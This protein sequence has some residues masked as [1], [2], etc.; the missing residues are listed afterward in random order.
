MFGGEIAIAT[1]VAEC[2]RTPYILGPTAAYTLPQD[3]A[4]FTADLLLGP[5]PG[6]EDNLLLPFA[7]GGCVEAEWMVF[8]DVKN[9]EFI[10]PIGDPYAVRMDVKLQ[11]LNCTTP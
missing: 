5:N 10:G 6:I 3:V 4:G 9:I 1:I 11:P 7:F 2:K 8:V